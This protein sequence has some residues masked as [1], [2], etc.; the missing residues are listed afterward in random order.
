MDHRQEL[1]LIRRRINENYKAN[2]EKDFPQIAT[3]TV[4]VVE[5]GKDV[6]KY[7]KGEFSLKHTFNKSNIVSELDCSNVVCAKGGF[8]LGE[9]IDDMYIKRETNEKGLK[10][11]FGKESSKSGKTSLRNCINMFSYEISITYR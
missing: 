11:C 1:S 9:L 4:I 2:F 6:D 8:L 10:M 3:I 7:N 5:E